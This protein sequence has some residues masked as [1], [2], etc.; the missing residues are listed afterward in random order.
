MN[1]TDFCRC[2][3]SSFY[4]APNI[5]RILEKID[6]AFGLTRDFL[7]CYLSS[8]NPAKEIVKQVAPKR[9]MGNLPYAVLELHQHILMRIILWWRTLHYRRIARHSRWCLFQSFC[10]WYHVHHAGCDQSGKNALTEWSC[11]TAVIWLI[12]CVSMSN[13][14]TIHDPIRESTSR[15]SIQVSTWSMT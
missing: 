6:K 14:L 12:F 15:L 8:R 4:A 7:A 11:S 5:A 2:N 13:T 10:I 3:L 9:C 1:W